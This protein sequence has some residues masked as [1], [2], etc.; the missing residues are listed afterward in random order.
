M[1]GAAAFAMNGRHRARARE[2]LQIPP[3]QPAGLR[4]A[5]A[6]VIQ[7]L[8]QGLVAPALG[9]GRP[10]RMDQIEGVPFRQYAFGQPIRLGQAAAPRPPR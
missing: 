3:L 6:R 8:Q 7:E 10:G 9:R 5:G 4:H 1:A 2:V